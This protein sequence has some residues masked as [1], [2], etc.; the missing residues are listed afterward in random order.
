MKK[1]SGVFAVL[2]VM[3]ALVI[4]S[5]GDRAGGNVQNPADSP[6]QPTQ[7]TQPTVVASYGATQSDITQ[8]VIFYSDNTWKT[9]MV[10]TMDGISCNL[11]T[12]SGT[13]SGNAGTDGTITITI[14]KM[15]DSISNPSGTSITNEDYPLLDYT[16]D[17]ATNTATISDSG[18]LLVTGGMYLPRL[19]TV[20]AKYSVEQNNSEMVLT[21]YSSNIWI[22]SMGG[23]PFIEMMGTYTGNCATNGMVVLTTT[24][25]GTVSNNNYTLVSLTEN[26][27]YSFPGVI[28]GTVIYVAGGQEFSCIG[29]SDDFNTDVVAAYSQRLFGTSAQEEITITLTFFNDNTWECT[30][31]GTYF[32]ATFNLIAYSGTYTG[33]PNQDG[34]LAMTKTQGVELSGQP[35]EG[36]NVTNENYPLSDISGSISG[37]VSGNIM[38]INTSDGPYYGTYIRTDNCVAAYNSIYDDDEQITWVFY[39]DN[40]WKAYIIQEGS[41]IDSYY[42][43]ATGT[44]TGNAVSNGLLPATVTQVYNSNNGELET[45]TGNDATQAFIIYNTKLLQ[46][47]PFASCLSD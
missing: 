20:V 37:T 26:Q 34:S 46:A 29:G 38:I 8:S 32:G 14:T 31:V 39:N 45:Y 23:T 22:I 21:F 12:V 28:S 13:Y 36:T 30:Y 11:T 3:M 6:T 47:I 5:C 18:T 33:N 4:T 43:M 15:V 40:T 10:G 17:D 35:Q 42:I 27:R 9:T 25:Q 44:Y 7:P 41:T 19:D 2:I 24:K 1:L 16:G